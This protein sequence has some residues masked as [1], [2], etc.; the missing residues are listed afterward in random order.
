MG[1][2][3]HAGCAMHQ[4]QCK[5]LERTLSTGASS[6]LPR[7]TCIG[8][9]VELNVLRLQMPAVCHKFKALTSVKADAAA[10]SDAEHNCTVSLAVLP[11]LL[12]S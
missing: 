4:E 2:V 7:V 11:L 3:L 8:Y 10:Q 6:A 9:R 1:A 12:I 5:W